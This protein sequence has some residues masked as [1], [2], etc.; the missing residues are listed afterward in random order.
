MTADDDRDDNVGI[1]DAATGGTHGVG[2]KETRSISLDVGCVRIE[3]DV[4]I[5]TIEETQ[6]E[7]NK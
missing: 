6:I 4:E 2:V 3:C 1:S 7:V 5:D